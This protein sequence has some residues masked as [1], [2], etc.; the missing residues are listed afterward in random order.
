MAFGLTTA[1]ASDL[2]G[3]GLASILV[4]LVSIARCTDSTIA[5]LD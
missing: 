1:V 5:L 3:R 4:S 2:A